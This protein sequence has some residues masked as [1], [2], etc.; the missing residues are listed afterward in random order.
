MVV[1]FF[2]FLPVAQAPLLLT[3]ERG[4][5]ETVKLLLDKGADIAQGGEFSNALQAAA[6]RGHLAVVEQL[7]Q[8]KAD[9]N[10]AAARNSGRTALQA[11]TETGYK[12]IV[13]ILCQ[14]DAQN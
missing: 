12:K 7:L 13:N 10:A 1:A 2:E 11:A 9:V 4:H 14:A 6:E 5:D 8:E 3:A